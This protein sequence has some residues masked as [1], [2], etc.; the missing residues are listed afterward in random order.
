[1][2]VLSSSRGFGLLFRSS[3]ELLGL[4][5]QLEGFHEFVT[6]EKRPPPHIY[7]IHQDPE[8]IAGLTVEDMQAW[9]ETVKEGVSLEVVG[10]GQAKG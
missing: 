6:S 3:D 1:M 9:L 2:I 4:A 7:H 8:E 10:A 5:R